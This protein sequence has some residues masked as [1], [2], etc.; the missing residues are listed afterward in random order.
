MRTRSMQKFFA[1]SLGWLVYFV[2]CV[3]AAPTEKMQGRA[4]LCMTMPL[5]AKAS[6]LIQFKPMETVDYLFLME[7]L[8]DTHGT[9]GVPSNKDYDS[10]AIESTR[11]SI[12]S[13]QAPRRNP[14]APPPMS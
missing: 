1:V 11:L 13:Q 6:G 9:Y 12:G 5:V 4:G 2:A 10:M 14:T 3:L 8:C 7:K